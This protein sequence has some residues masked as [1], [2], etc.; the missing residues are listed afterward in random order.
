[1]L[2]SSKTTIFFGLMALNLVLDRK[3]K[4]K[5]SKKNNLELPSFKNTLEV[6][7]SI[8]GRIRFYSPILKSNDNLSNYLLDQ[9]KKIQVIKLCTINTVTGTILIEYDHENLDPQTLEGAIIKLLGLD[10]DIE[11]G[12]VSQIRK[13]TSNIVSALD[14]GIYD[15]S[16]GIL[17]LKSLTVIGFFVA[18]FLDYRNYGFRTPDYM[19]LLWWSA[20]LI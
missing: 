14:S 9:V 20:S 1:M 4:N 18:A 15:F 17:D 10:K 7:S 13:E 2:L 12:R 3:M 5:V 16:N 8:K 6:R 19:T 11:D